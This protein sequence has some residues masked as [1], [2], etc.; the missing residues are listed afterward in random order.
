MADQSQMFLKIKINKYNKMFKSKFLYNKIITIMDNIK[1]GKIQ[2]NK[3]I[4]INNNK[5]I[6]VKIILNK[7]YISNMVFNKVISRIT[8]MVMVNIKVDMVMEGYLNSNRIDN[9]KI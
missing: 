1:I 5:V 6:T 3:Y 7:M 9:C 2:I 4:L 8:D